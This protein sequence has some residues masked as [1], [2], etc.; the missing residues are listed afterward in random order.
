MTD[1]S[2]FFTTTSTAQSFPVT[3]PPEQQSPL[4]N[5]DASNANLAEEEEYTIKC[6][7]GYA[8]DDG[9]TVYC[10]KC[11]TWQ[12][13]EC[14]YPSKKVPDEHF[15]SDCLPREV[16]A[17]RAAERQRRH[18]EGPLEGG[19]RKVKRPNT[20]TT[21]KKHKDSSATAEQING[22]HLDRHD[23][24]SNGRDQPPPAKKPKTSHRT[25]GSVAS[26]NGNGNGETRKR[27]LSN[28]HYP[29]PSKSPPDAARY[30]PIPLY[31]T[32]FLELY[33]HDQGTTDA[34]ANEHTIP[35]LKELSSWRSTPSRIA[36]PGEA[37]T[38]EAPFVSAT[39]PLDDSVYPPVSVQQTERRDVDIDGKSPR[40]KYIVTQQSIP[41]DTVVG[42]IRGEVGMLDEYC[43]Q[44]SQNRWQELSHP[45]PFVFFH[46]HMNIY[47][48]SRKQG[49]QF[50]YLRRS[51]NP[52]IT[53]KTFITQDGDWRH[54][55]VSKADISAGMELTSTWFL[56]G[57]MTDPPSD[58]DDPPF[59]RQCDWVSRVLANFGDCA[60]NKGGACLFSRF[61]R[62]TLL[63]SSD[64][65][66]KGKPG[67]KKKLKSK[68][69]M[70]PRST[71]PN[72]RAGS[73][74]L[75]HEDDEVD[76]RST[77]GSA[78]EPKSRDMTPSNIA[79]LDAPPL[80]GSQLTDREIRK[81]KALEQ[82]EQEKNKT[83][84]KKTKKRTSG[85]S[86]VNTPVPQGHRL[87]N[88]GT[89]QYPGSPS[90]VAGT[91]GKSNTP[92]Q[93]PSK[94]V[95]VEAATQTEP[96]DVEIELPPAKR[97]KYV[98]PQQ[99]LL[100]KILANRSRYEQRCQAAGIS[101][102]S[103]SGTPLTSPGR[104]VEMSDLATAVSPVSARS[105]LLPSPST[106]SDAN[107]ASPVV[108][109]TYPLPSQAA[110]SQ[111][112][113]KVPAPKLQILSM[114]AVPTFNSASSPSTTGTPGNAVAAQSPMALHAPLLTP[115]ASTPTPSPARKKLSLGDYM[116]SRRNTSSGTSI[117][118]E[119]PSSPESERKVSSE[120]P[121][122]PE[123]T[124]APPDDSIKQEAAMISIPEVAVED[125]P[126]K[127]VDEEAEYSPPEAVI[128]DTAPSIVEQA[129][130]K[131][132]LQ[133]AA[134]NLV[135]GS[136]EVNNVLARLAQMQ[137]QAH[138]GTS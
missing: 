135:A 27:A 123:A 33:D 22:W 91:R 122:P 111:K 70:S 68:A 43:Q 74:A 83:K 102:N 106:S 51:C 29:S 55:F 17:K 26:V 105:A 60:C 10:E 77:S 71:G 36:G 98:T 15:C 46:P 125:T 108:S 47:V 66:E 63:K 8:D 64:G 84:E 31:T 87:V 109:P 131:P 128:D 97:M 132:E 86:N 2:S 57:F 24:L 110:H 44:H 35:A 21:K 67:R 138:N 3:A 13:I 99:R 124:H 75:K 65:P 101:P 116:K 134:D 121:A 136:T 5:G 18:R 12:H 52:N 61:D 133:V 107:T 53:L 42:E 96:D 41:R 81:L 76:Q 78:S 73:E 58:Q 6:I 49:T 93:T 23:S 9:N 85:G 126:M 14:Y 1:S 129:G 28:I 82:R 94:P 92:R 89:E 11:D 59:A 88:S 95:Y 103:Q 115:T 45:D 50:R 19:D 113:F 56:P 137:G 69:V 32:E 127:D 16:D 120:S 40:W 118:N 79:A 117:G 130:N 100:R 112:Q 48:D 39:G 104:E 90:I 38:M 62:R 4:L 80:L 37:P 34:Q 30:P 7:C 54:C 20:K 114:P 119:K 25:S 72:S